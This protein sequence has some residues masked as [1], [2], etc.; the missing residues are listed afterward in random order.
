MDFENFA[1]QIKS[2]VDFD[3]FEKPL[4]EFQ[5]GARLTVDK[6][7]MVKKALVKTKFSQL[8]DKRFYFSNGVLSLP[9]RHLN[10]RKIDDSKKRKGT[11]NCEIFFERIRRVI[12]NRKK[13]TQ[14]SS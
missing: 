12:K 5:Q 14:K 6:G 11:E 9:F 10:L 2:W 13:S 8:N 1:N 4:A 7:E 3:T